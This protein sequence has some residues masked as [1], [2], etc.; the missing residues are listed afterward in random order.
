MSNAYIFELDKLDKPRITTRGERWSFFTD[1]VM[2]GLS[3]GQ[4]SVSNLSQIIGNVTNKKM[5]TLFQ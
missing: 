2:V 4:T 3:Y 5:V 1:G